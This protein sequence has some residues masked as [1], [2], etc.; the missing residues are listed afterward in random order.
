MTDALRNLALSILSG[1][2]ALEAAYSKAGI[3]LPSLDDSFV[4]SPLDKDGA[5]RDAQRLVASAAS[6]IIAHARQPMESLQEY[7]MGMYM[8]A[9]LGFVVD[10]NIPDILKGAGQQVSQSCTLS[11]RYSYARPPSRD[12]T[13][14]TSQ[15]RPELTQRS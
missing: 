8:T 2:D 11:T 15:P 13:W 3:S 7:A 12:S 6:Q 1:V 14:Q 4:P 5:V 10:A 9:T